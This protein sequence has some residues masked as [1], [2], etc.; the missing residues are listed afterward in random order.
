[1]ALLVM[2]ST[3]MTALAQ[4]SHPCPE[5][6]NAVTYPN[7]PLTYPMTSNRYAVQYQLGGAG[8][9]TNAQVY[10][11]YYGGS[12]S[13]PYVNASGYPADESMSFVSIPAGASTAVAIRVSKI[14]GSNFPAI[15]QMSVRPNAKGIQ[16][17][18]VSATTVQLGTTTAADFAGDQFVLWWN[19]G[20]QQSSSIQGLAIFLDPPY[21]RPTGSSVKVV[22]TPADL[23]GDLSTFD[24][25][26]IEGTVAVG[27][28]GDQA[29]IV[30]A[31]IDNIFLAAGAWLQGKL[32]FTQSGSGNT[33]KIYGP[34]VL[35]VS[36][37]NYA[38]RHCQDSTGHV[39]DGYQS[40][41]WI[42]VGA[43]GQP[44][45]FVIDGLIVSDS[46]FYATDQFSNSTVN[47]MKIIGWN[48]NND[49]IQLGLSVGVSNVFVRTGDDSLK[50]WGSS[51]TVTNATVWQN[52]NG[53]VVNLGWDDNPHGDD[54]L[55][56]GL[57]VVKTDWSSSN[58][59]SFTNTGL[60][61]DNDAI[62]ASLMTPSVN[63]GASIPSVYRNIYVEDPPRVLFSL[64][65]SPIECAGTCPG[66]GQ[67]SVLNLNLENVSTP[68]S[69]LDNPIGFQTVSDSP[70]PGSM[71]I[72]LTNVMLTQSNGAVTP[73]TSANAGSLGKIKTNG[74]HIDITYP[75]TPTNMRLWVLPSPAIQGQDVILMASVVP[76]GATGTVSF[77]DGSSSLGTA[78]LVGGFAVM[79]VKALTAGYHA[80]SATYGGDTDYGPTLFPI[81][82][83]TVNP[84]PLATTTMLSAGS[85]S[86]VAGQSV[87]LTATV[88]PSAATGT[89]T[90]QDGQIA[91]GSAPLS[92]GSASFS[93]STLAA[94]NHTLT[95][96]YGGDA[97]D[98]PSISGP[99]MLTVSPAAPPSLTWV[100]GSTVKLYQ[101]N[102]D[103]D[104]VDWDATINNKAPTCNRTTS[105]TETKADVLG[106]DVPVV[107]E[108]NGELIVTFGD[109]IGAAGL[110][111]WTNVQNSFQWQAHDPI[112][113]SSTTNASDGLLLNFFLSGNHG[114][115]VQPV[116]PD[117]TLIDMGADNVPNTGVSL[118][119]Q[120]YLGIKAGSVNVGPGDNDLSGAYSL[121]S[122]F[123]ENAGTFAAGRI[124]S[125]SPD[126]HFIL[127]TF[128]QAPPG[129]LSPP[130][131]ST[132]PVMLIF[133]L[134]QYRASN[135]YLS[136]VPS[137][138]FATGMDQNGNPATQYFAGMSQGQPAWSASEADAVP[139]V[140]DLDPANPTIGNLSVFY[141]QP[142]GLWLMV[143]DGGRGS[144]TTSGMY[145]TYASQPWGPWSTPQL[146]F[147]D[148]RDKGLGN[149]V[150]YHYATKGE[151]FCPSAMPAGVTSAPNSAG[152]SGPTIGD[153]TKNDPTTTTGGAYAP[154]FVERFTIVSGDTLK[155]FYM[156]STWNP[157]AVVMMESDFQ[158]DR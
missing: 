15:S 20:P 32:R 72:A 154:A 59:P 134:G 2:A 88:T 16:I 144:T 38:Y 102:G 99:L 87:T 150:F 34:G 76:L 75:K 133:G 70:L 45:S 36:R 121:L 122:T 90:L 68:P 145:F 101:V 66:L 137:T 77:F 81:L 100:P 25:L 33:R 50:M 4:Q 153:Q 143:Y 151:N 41:S 11:S 5:T 12:N 105:Q 98:A 54:C 125:S 149:F 128:Y 29:F 49:G 139:I 94:G 7:Q 52:W 83:L 96:A 147:N 120:I 132:D 14:W 141:S 156:F 74:S 78:S 114:L 18:S 95:A 85:A 55:I 61:S 127:P 37:F 116:Q 140:T 43:N 84:A 13:S 142:L 57:Y 39:D 28:T 136:I 22:A 51:I 30:P 112:A 131:P 126:G 63:F 89:V 146:V 44:D 130:P 129:V 135:I 10:I 115:E 148:C 86:P 27:G 91:I 118:N 62:I 71:N 69:T 58:T 56:D 1:M 67:P 103:C 65:V 152:P 158:I 40:I 108:H 24:T 138:Q 64:K 21:V 6:S 93:V 117:G 3:A 97:G 80:L 31:N 104:W 73:L 9:W 26:D 119:G 47:N 124:I 113:R 82:N 46:D 109:T 23:T 19:G 157:Y 17:G 110:G 106:D 8:T 123:D 42:P 53:G 107:F 79:T 48:S 111:K 35:D 92:G 155:L 60:N